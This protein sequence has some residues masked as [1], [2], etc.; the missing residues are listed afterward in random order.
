MV[1][2]TLLVILRASRTRHEPLHVCRLS[3]TSSL[4][5]GQPNYGG[6]CCATMENC[7]C[8]SYYFR[9]LALP[10]PLSL[11]HLRLN[12]PSLRTTGVSPGTDCFHLR[13]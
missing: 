7:C 3:L 10:T 1:F 2:I 8:Y 4:G 5:N 13:G 11:Y 12:H 6:Y 9:F